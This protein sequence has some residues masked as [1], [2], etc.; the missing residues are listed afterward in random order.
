M[1]YIIQSSAIQNSDDYIEYCLKINKKNTNE[2]LNLTQDY[3]TGFYWI[4]NYNFNRNCS[5]ENI[6]YVSS[7]AYSH[8]YPPT[9]HMIQEYFIELKRI[10]DKK[11]SREISHYNYKYHNC[12]YDIVGLYM[13]EQSKDIFSLEKGIIYIERKNFINDIE[14]IMLINPVTN[15]E[16]EHNKYELP[17]KYILLR[18][19]NDIFQNIDIIVNEMYIA[20]KNKISYDKIIIF[21][22]LSLHKYI[23][24]LLKYNPERHLAIL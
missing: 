19:N 24:L 10:I 5:S 1:Y 14:R 17:D 15:K 21:P 2:K 20:L 8:V 18:K 23:E 16:I 7:W 9:L 3:I 6:K 22:R 4:M 13:K 12:K 11:L